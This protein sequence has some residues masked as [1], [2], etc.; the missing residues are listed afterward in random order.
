MDDKFSKR[1]FSTRV[2][3]SGTNN[4]EGSAVTPIF[5]TSTYKLTDERYRKWMETGGQHTLL[6]SRYSSVNSEAVAA[7]VAALE[8]AEDGEAFGSGM[9]AISSTLLSLLS[10]GDHVVTSADIYGGTYGLMTSD[11]PRYGIE[12]TMAD[13]RDPPSFEAAINENTKV[14]YVETITNPVL[15]VCDLEE[16][17]SIAKKHGLVSIVDNTFATPW[18]CRPIPM[19]FDLVIHSGTKFLNGHTDLTAGIVVGKKDLIKGVFEAKARFG[20]AADP[21]MCYLLERGMRT[22]HARMPIHASNSSEIARRLEEHPAITSV[23][24]PSLPS[25]AD[26]EV[27]KRIAPKGTGMLSFAV[28]GGDENALRFIRALEIVFEAT[29]LGGIESLVECPFNTSHSFVPEEVRLEAGIVPGFVRMS[30]GIE[31]VEDLWFDIDQALRAS[32]L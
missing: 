10:K 5:T 16:M 24:H 26:Y 28:K 17:A 3:W 13:I 22:L 7:K 23:N 31:D 30:V 4:I 15:K 6:Y 18:A 11:L 32:Q 25:F 2:V 27:A 9:A 14:L 19:G 21:H 1:E 12:V 8:G 29:S 20:G